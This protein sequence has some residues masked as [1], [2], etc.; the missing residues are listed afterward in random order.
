MY[1]PFIKRLQL[2][3]DIIKS[4]T[5]RSSNFSTFATKR[6]KNKKSPIPA[7]TLHINVSS[8]TNT[9]HTALDNSHIHSAEKDH[10]EIP[11]IIMS[12]S[13]TPK[14]TMII[15]VLSDVSAA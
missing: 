8:L 14:G 4:K 13:T 3:K 12:P 5:A 10:I 9:F 6:S 7:T 1:Y 15:L 11:Q 2:Q